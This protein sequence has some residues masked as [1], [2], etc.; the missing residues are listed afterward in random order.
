MKG[1]SRNFTFSTNDYR[2]YFNPW[3]TSQLKSFRHELIQTLPIE[4][5]IEYHY[6]E[7][8]RYRFPKFYGYAYDTFL[9]LSLLELSGNKRVRYIDEFL[10]NYLMDKRK[11]CVFEH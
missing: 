11:K 7:G 4:S 6:D 2:N 9:V 3:I 1:Y 10:Y 5:L 8:L